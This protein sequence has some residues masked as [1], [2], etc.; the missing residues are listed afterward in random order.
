MTRKLEPV[1]I[2]SRAAE[3][4]KKIKETKNIPGDYGLR[5]GI[6]G[7]GCGA[8]LVVGF[9]KQRENDIMYTV[10]GV[11]VLVDKHHT[12]YVVGKEIDFYDGEDARGFLFKEPKG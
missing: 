7:G 2:S 3:E 8:K 9:D 12:L 4:I 1:N 5:V 6:R 11:K 10:S